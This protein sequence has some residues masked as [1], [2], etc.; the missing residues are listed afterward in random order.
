M[1]GTKPPNLP[2]RALAQNDEVELSRYKKTSLRLCVVPVLLIAI[3]WSVASGQDMEPRA[4]SRA[5]VG[6]QYVVL[7]YVHQK[8]DVLLDS[9]LP[10]RDVSVKLNFGMLG[11]GRTFNLSGRQASVSV[12]A[13]YILGRAQGAVFEGRTEARRSGLG[14]M[15][16]RFA[17]NLIGG[18]ALSPREFAAY[19]PRTLLGASLT[20]VVPTGQYDPRRLVN[21]GSNRWAFKPEVGLSK[22]FGRWTVELAGGVWFFTRNNNFFGGV[23]REQKAIQTVQA[24]VIYTLRPRMWLALNAT[25]YT[26]GRTVVNGVVNAD[27]QKN[28]RL[29]GTFSLPVGS[30]QSI[31]V[32]WAKGVTARFGGDLSTVAV[33]WQYT[34]LK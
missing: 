32:A 33:G 34:W 10:L 5:P 1:I 22:P 4:Y 14:D 13:P 8:G 26:G 25:Y 20:V 19:K 18:P 16:L 17:T 24:H 7:S 11:Y 31:K 6:T 12:L 28:S 27:T 15:R 3:F 9:S 2:T 21:I 29:G 23:K 30:R